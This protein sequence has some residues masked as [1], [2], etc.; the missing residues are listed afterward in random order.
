MSMIINISTV[1]MMWC[2]FSHLCNLLL[3]I[4]VVV[5]KIRPVIVI[6]RGAILDFHGMAL[7]KTGI[8]LGEHLGSL[9]DLLEFMSWLRYL[10]G[11]LREGPRLAT[12]AFFVESNRGSWFLASRS[13]D[14]FQ[15]FGAMALGF[16]NRFPRN[17][18]I[19]DQRER[20]LDLVIIG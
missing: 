1:I 7:H 2:Y 6:I 12:P 20:M 8:T 10:Y 9:L 14:R 19:T 16:L 15:E 3:I 5:C 11:G 13:V 4:T 18:A 17:D